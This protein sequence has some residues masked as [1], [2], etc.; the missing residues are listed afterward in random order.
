MLREF[1]TALTRIEY[2]SYETC[3]NCDEEIGAKRL[4]AVPWT[5]LSIACQELDDQ[6]VALRRQR[7]NGP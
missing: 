3:L 2:G 7:S 1:R 6:R 4:R 5:S